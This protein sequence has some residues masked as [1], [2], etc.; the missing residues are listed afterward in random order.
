MTDIGLMWKRHR[1][2]VIIDKFHAKLK[3]YSSKIYFGK[4]ILQK[5]NKM[6]IISILAIKNLV[7]S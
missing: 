2:P 1:N 3:Q 7:I 4:A 5:V 6:L